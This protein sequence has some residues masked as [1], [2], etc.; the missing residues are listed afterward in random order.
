MSVDENQYYHILSAF[1]K[2]L[3]GSDSNAALY[4]SQ[5]LIKAGCDP[6]IIARRLIVHSAEDVGLAD[7]NALVVATSALTA[8]Q[9]IGVPEGLIPLSEAIIYVC[10]AP[11]SNSV[12]V[13]MDG[14]SSDAENIRDDDIPP[15]LINPVYV[16]KEDKHKSANYKYPHDYGG[17][18]EQQYLPNK[19]LGKE[20][21]KPTNNGFEKTVQEI[22]KNKTGK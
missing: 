20:Y 17:W 2:S 3:R 13:A 10:E 6:L 9:N 1:C 19:L 7:P 12:I 18:V 21:Y 8:M 5:R 14:A 22:R 4:Y 11:K 16:S 15:H